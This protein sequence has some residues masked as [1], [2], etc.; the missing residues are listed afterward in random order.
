MTYKNRSILWRLFLLGTLM[1][2]ACGRLKSDDSEQIVSNLTGTLPIE[3]VN[4]AVVGQPL[5]L[6][7]GPIQA[8]DGTPATLTLLGSYGPQILY[9]TFKNNHAYFLIPAD[10]TTRSGRLDLVVTS[11]TAKGATAL[12]LQP[13]EPVEPITLLV[14]PRSIIADADHWAMALAIPF[15]QFGNPIAE[16]TNVDFRSLHPGENLRTYNSKIEHLLVWERVFSGT[17]AGRTVIAANIDDV[18]GPEGILLE[19]PGWPVPFSIMSDPVTLPA[20]GF[21][22]MT[23]YTG[24]ITDQ[25]GNIMPDGTLVRFVV[26][27]P[28]E[29]L[30]I[31][32]V[33]TVDGIAETIFQAP[34]NQGRYLIR[35]AVFGMESDPLTVEFTPGPAVSPFP[36]IYE[37]NSERGDLTLTAGPLTAVL[38]QYV[39]DGTP[40]NF[41]ITGP[42]GESHPVQ[43]VSDAGYATGTIRLVQLTGG[44]HQ[45]D[46]SAGSGL[47]QVRFTLP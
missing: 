23:L 40:V 25:H 29:N 7:V 24:K 47:G 33:Q 19:I 3:V 39:P 26:N 17:K 35:A 5:D 1:L 27:G 45:V 36:V 13:E 4:T 22:L 30:R 42:D 2:A 8:T 18:S 21:Q 38:D 31:I 32:P 10:M 34:N 44:I 15:D 16:E 11:G 6:L 9:T 20:D 37:I 12:D 43:A 28:E 41:R 46:A 14:G